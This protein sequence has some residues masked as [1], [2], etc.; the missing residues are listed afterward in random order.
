MPQYQV[1]AVW[2]PEGWEPRSPLDVPNCLARA[3]EPCAIS[4][5]MD[6]KRAL[7]AARGLNRQNMD[8]PGVTWYVVTEVEEETDRAAGA[9]RPLRA[10]GP[11][12]GSG[13]GDCSHCPA[14][15]FPC[16][17]ERH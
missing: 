2:W 10:L 8:H 14:R 15:E 7:A 3:P 9:D 16:S 1:T 4:P 17:A 11:V 12:E 13:R 6:C 5:A